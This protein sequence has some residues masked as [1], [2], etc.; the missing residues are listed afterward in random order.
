MIFE[1]DKSNTGAHNQK[2][3]QERKYEKYEFKVTLN[4]LIFAEFADKSAKN[5]LCEICHTLLSVKIHPREI[6][7]VP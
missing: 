2:H 5:F 4:R 1:G 3:V 6:S 7:I